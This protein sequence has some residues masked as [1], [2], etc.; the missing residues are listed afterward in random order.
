MSRQHAL[1]GV[2]CSCDVGELEELQQK[3]EVC[4]A[5]LAD[6]ARGSDAWTAVRQDLVMLRQTRVIRLQQAQGGFVALGIASII[7]AYTY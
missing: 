5:K 6:F 3:I 2:C 7:E 1:R 4:E